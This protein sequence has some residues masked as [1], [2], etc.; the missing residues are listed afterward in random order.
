MVG[1]EI[2][3]IILGAAITIVAL[4]LLTISLISY[5]RYR[6]KKLLFVVIV[7]LFFLIRG[8]LLS[9]S[10]FYEPLQPIVTSY[11]LWIIDLIVLTLLYLAALQR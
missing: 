7:F 3:F 4:I 8:V 1:I 10:I 5:R 6:N 2:G 11:Y 9:A